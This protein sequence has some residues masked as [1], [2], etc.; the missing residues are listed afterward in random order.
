[1]QFTLLPA[2]PVVVGIR[3][4]GVLTETDESVRYVYWRPGAGCCA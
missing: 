2:R 1:M 4:T 3:A